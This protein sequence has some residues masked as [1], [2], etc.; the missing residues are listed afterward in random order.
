MHAGRMAKRHDGRAKNINHEAKPG[1]K[2]WQR[3]MAHKL[4]SHCLPAT[5]FS[6]AAHAWEK[7]GGA[8]PL[9]MAQHG[10]ARGAYTMP[11]A[12]AL[13]CKDVTLLFPQNS[14]ESPAVCP[15]IDMHAHAAAGVEDAHSTRPEMHGGV[16]CMRHVLQPRL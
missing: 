10:R 3:P 14:H 8:L 12:M 5:H 4:P 11:S 7:V 1:A 2:R 9:S 15:V 13:D 6:Q 16:W